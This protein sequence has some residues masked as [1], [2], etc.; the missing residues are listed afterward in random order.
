[1]QRRIKYGVSTLFQI[2]VCENIVD[3][4]LFAQ[5]L[6]GELSDTEKVT[7]EKD[8]IALMKSNR[9]RLLGILED[10][11]AYFTFRFR[12]YIKHI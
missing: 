2:L 8:L 7:T 6:E 4:R 1:M 10:Y 5:L 3:D 11:P 12:T 9:Q